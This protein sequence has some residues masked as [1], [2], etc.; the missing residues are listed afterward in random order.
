MEAETVTMIVKHG[1]I[2]HVDGGV[3][4]AGERV[5]VPVGYTNKNLRPLFVSEAPALP[6]ITVDDVRKE[7]FAE[8]IAVAGVSKGSIDALCKEY[9]Q[10]IPVD[11]AS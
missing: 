11:D 9:P 2:I 6:E 7:F 1:C 10:Y 5:E 8:V 3:K 4:K